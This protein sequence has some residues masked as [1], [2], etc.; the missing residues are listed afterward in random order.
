MTE[1]KISLRQRSLS[2]Q[3]QS[4]LC[5]VRNGADS[6]DSETEPAL[7]KG[8]MG[9]V[10][11][12][13]APNE[14]FGPGS[15]FSVGWDNVGTRD[16]FNEWR[17]RLIYTDF[18]L[19]LS[20]FIKGPVTPG[21]N[22]TGIMGYENETPV[23]R[24]GMPRTVTGPVTLL[25][26]GYSIG[27]PNPIVSISQ[28]VQ[29]VDSGQF[30]LQGTAGGGTGGFSATDRTNLLATLAAVTTSW[31]SGGALNGLIDFISHPTLNLVQPTRIDPP[32][33]G[34][35]RLIRPGLPG[36][37]FGVNAFGLVWTIT[38]LPDGIGKI[39]GNPLTWRPRILQLSTIHT[40]ADGTDWIT[41]EQSF[42]IN[43]FVWR[44]TEPIPTYVDYAIVPGGTVQFSWLTGRT[45]L[46]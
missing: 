11:G 28:P 36:Q 38:Q 46:P 27:N 30:F 39:D 22:I 9:Y 15:Q 5:W 8:V 24:P 29:Y 3:P 44:W 12:Y 1:G 23:I 19:P 7:E 31:G 35:G 21:S 42:S 18:N 2:F 17:V 43:Q 41:E 10:F 45:T 37:D 6:P 34:K 4:S 16:P 13:P 40:L 14:A 32:R 26:E 33:Q 25:A 20:Q